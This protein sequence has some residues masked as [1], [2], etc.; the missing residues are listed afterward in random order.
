VAKKGSNNSFLESLKNEYS[1]IAADGLASSEFSGFIDT[2]SYALNAACSGSIFGGIPDNKI[3]GLAGHSQVGKSYVALGILQN[4]LKNDPDA[5]SVYYDTENATRRVVM[6]DRGIDTNRVLISEPE[7]IQKFRTHCLNVL[8]AYQKVPEKGRQKMMLVLDS[9]GMLPTQK[10]MEDSSSGHD[11]K[12]MTRPSTI[13]SAF[14]T[15]TL[16]LGK[17]KVP[18]ILTNHIYQGMGQYVPEEQSGGGGVKYACDTILFLSSA[19]VKIGEGAEAEVVGNYI[20]VKVKKSR[21]TKADTKIK[22]RLSYTHGLD[23]Y[24]GLLPIAV[25]GGV[26]KKSS[27]KII[28]PDGTSEFAK[29]IENNPE[30][31]FTPEILKL[32]DAAAYKQFNYGIHDQPEV[33]TDDDEL[34]EDLA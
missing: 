22:L 6:E 24:Y 4:F 32:I 19:K 3:L 29:T 21:L 34:L 2:G 33:S 13:R 7:T 23:R 25:K 20:I 10:E 8:E 16:K 17:C 18:L 26:F 14:R 9:L 27:T 12:D 5:I 11:A 28:L 30:K 31:Y 15:L 1:T